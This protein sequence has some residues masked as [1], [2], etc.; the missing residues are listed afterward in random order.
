[1]HATREGEERDDTRKRCMHLESEQPSIILK[2][3]RTNLSALILKWIK[4][5]KKLKR[6]KKKKKKK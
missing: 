2:W 5:K 6:K 3:I 1:V 4:I